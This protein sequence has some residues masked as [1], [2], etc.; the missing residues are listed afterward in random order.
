MVDLEVLSAQGDIKQLLGQFGSILIF[1]SALVA[2]GAM[3]FDPPHDGQGRRGLAVEHPTLPDCHH[4]AGHGPVR[5]AELGF[6]FSRPPRCT[7]AGAAAGAPAHHLPGQGRGP[8]RRPRADDR[9]SQW[10]PRDHLGADA[11]RS[12]AQRPAWWGPRACCLLDRDPGWGGVCLLRRPGSARD[13]RPTAAPLVSP[14]FGGAA[15]R[16][17]A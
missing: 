12:R 4:H 6:H 15:N 8:R 1:F 3:F 5:C 16:S 11:F 17:S 7:G 2:L 9:C 13:S 10:P 14:V